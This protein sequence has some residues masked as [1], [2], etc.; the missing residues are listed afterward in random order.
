M[1]GKRTGQ[2]LLRFDRSLGVRYVA[3]H[4]P[5]YEH[6]GLVPPACQAQAERGL[7]RLGLRRLVSGGPIELWSF[8]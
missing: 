8:P 7:T 5:M 1:A 6:T 2:K 4:A 3:V